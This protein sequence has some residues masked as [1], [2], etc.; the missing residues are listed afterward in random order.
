MA[1][2]RDLLV[3]DLAVLESR[4]AYVRGC[5]GGHVQLCGSDRG[6]TFLRGLFA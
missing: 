2:G 4:Q 6:F 5:V 1:E 3:G